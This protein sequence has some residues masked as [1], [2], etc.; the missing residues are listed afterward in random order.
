VIYLA[1]TVGDGVVEALAGPGAGRVVGVFSRGFY[2]RTPH[3][4]AAVGGPALPAGPVHITLDVEGPR[5]VEGDLV[6][7]TGDVLAGPGWR[8][9]LGSASRYRPPL[10]PRGVAQALVNVDDLLGGGVAGDAVAAPADLWREWPEVVAT[11][12]GG[13]LHAARRVLQGRGAGLTPTGDD[14]LAGLLLVGAWT[15]TGSAAPQAVAAQ[16]DTTELSRSFL[17][18]A[19]RG[20]S[21]APVHELVEV[22]LRGDRTAVE[23]AARRVARMGASS[24]RAL[25]AGLRLGA[26]AVAREVRG[27]DAA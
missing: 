26:L 13:D 1:A 15:Q 24:G 21:V 10:P 7:V 12:A 8:V 23:Y 27:C 14:V 6:V 18:W 16:A 9:E 17:H 19:A 22:A 3:G 25:L 4:L 5:L 11:V 20:Q 2:V